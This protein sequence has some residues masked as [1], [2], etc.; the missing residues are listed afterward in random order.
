MIHGKASGGKPYEGNPHVWFDEGNVASA[1]PRHASLLYTIKCFS[2]LL[3]LSAAF[4][5]GA[6]DLPFWGDAE[7]ATNR[8]SASCQTVA[9]SY[10]FESRICAGDEVALAT[11]DSRPKGATFI[12]R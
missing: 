11:F 5:T 7:P 1:A 9:L 3:G 10:S 2:L 12:I 6:T 4:V 8:T